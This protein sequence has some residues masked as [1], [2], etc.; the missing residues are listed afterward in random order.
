MPF[1]ACPAPCPTDR[2]VRPPGFSRA[3]TWRHGVGRLVAAVALLTG[4]MYGGGC[5]VKDRQVIAQAES[6]HGELQKAV[7]TDPQ[8][9][10]Y[11]QQV[12]DRIVTAGG[13]LYKSGK[14]KPKK[15]SGEDRSWMFSTNTMRFHFVNSETLNAFTTGGEHMYVYTELLRQCKNENELAAV[16]A[17]EYAHVFGRHVQSGMTRQTLAMIGTTGAAGAA[18]LAGGSEK[19]STYSQ[20]AGTAAGAIAGLATAGFTRGDESEADELGFR[21]YVAAGWDPDQF[22][23]FFRTL[24]GVEK[25]S[26]R[27]SGG[28]AEFTSDHP[29]TAARV[30]NAEKWAADYK[31][32]NPDWQSKLV[33]PVADESSFSQI[34]ARSTAIAS[35]MPSDKAL[36]AQKLATALPRS[37]LWPDEPHPASAR[38]AQEG[39]KKDIQA[40]EAAPAAGGTR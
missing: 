25:S 16:M 24:L 3:P 6:T 26:G 2:T 17:H 34:K 15:E 28:L 8:M 11:I 19:G 32:K 37:C 38:V 7:V 36:T 9:A 40:K 35:Q 14:A 18:Q 4:V 22:A 29:S 12:G 20:Y 27:S 23:G 30:A 1:A 10:P 31:R 33:R 13:E 21:F 39:L 5:A